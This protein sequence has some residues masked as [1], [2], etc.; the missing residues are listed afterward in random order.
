MGIARD[1]AAEAVTEVFADIDER[2][3]LL[4]AIQKKLRGKKVRTLQ[5]RARLYRFLIR[6]G[7]PP[8]AVSSALRRLG[9]GDD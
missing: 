2:S 1:V 6:Q 7:F 8:A 5:E 3:L 9:A 4:K